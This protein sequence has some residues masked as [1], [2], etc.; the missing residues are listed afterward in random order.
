MSYRFKVF[1]FNE[2][3]VKGVNKISKYRK[4]GFHAVDCAYGRADNLIVRGGL[5]PRARQTFQSGVF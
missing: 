3:D 4:K 2:N 1:E 5:I